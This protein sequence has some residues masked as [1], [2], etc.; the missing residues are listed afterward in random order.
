MKRNLIAVLTLVLLST[1]A[2]A[3]QGRGGDRGQGGPGGAPG[4]HAIVAPDGTIFITRD[5]ATEG[6]FELVA[7]R[8][9]GTTAWTATITGRSNL[10]LSG[11]N[12]LQVSQTQATETTPATTTIR[13]IST[14]S[15][16]VA[17]TATLNGRVTS[18]EPFSGG[19][20]AIVV[21]PAATAGGAATRSLV[22]ISNSGPTLWTV[23][24]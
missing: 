4:G 2:F 6:S 22:A 23:A 7:I 15:G 21:T 1:S 11:S 17:W 10:Q 20:Y 16:Q 3:Q 8:P 12:L 19:T 18:L 14:S 5:S 13:A 9:T 24:L